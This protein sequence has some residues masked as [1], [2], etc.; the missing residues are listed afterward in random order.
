VPDDRI[1]LVVPQDQ[2]KLGQFLAKLVPVP[3]R[4]LA[5]PQKRCER[6]FDFARAVGQVGALRVGEDAHRRHS[7]RVLRRPVELQTAYVVRIVTSRN[8][9]FVS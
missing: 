3:D 9:T 6:V 7:A 1:V 4:D 2:L 8:P 5:V